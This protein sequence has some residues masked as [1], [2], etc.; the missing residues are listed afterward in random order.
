MQ[1]HHIKRK[2]LEKNRERTLD[3]VQYE[4]GWPGAKYYFNSTKVY[5]PIVEGYDS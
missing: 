2:I 5:L 1:N 3:E 4:K